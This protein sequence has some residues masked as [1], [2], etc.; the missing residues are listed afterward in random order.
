MAKPAPISVILSAMFLAA[1][2]AHAAERVA[3]SARVQVQGSS[4]A[5]AQLLPDQ[6]PFRM[7][8]AAAQAS[9]GS[10]PAYGSVRQI[11]RAEIVSAMRDAG[12]N[13]S[14]FTI[15]DEVTVMRSGR[16]LSRIEIFHAIE[17]FYKARWPGSQ[18]AFSPGDIEFQ[19]S[20]RV[21]EGDAAL[22]V[23]GVRYDQML[24]REIVRLLSESRP[25][26]VP[27]EV[28]VKMLP[29]P[30]TAAKFAPARHSATPSPVLVDPRYPAR[31]YLLSN[32]AEITMQVRPLQRG[33]RG[34]SIRV[35]LPQNGHT[36]L[37]RVV[38]QNTLEASF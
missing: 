28:A 24:N 37:A 9:L 19:N 15:P 12:L 4:V 32:A 33:R 34:D 27:F 25:D 5:L 38:S 2:S 20:I 18:V 8:A 22:S 3:I 16:T 30:G 17:S 11:Q 36:F 31:L 7:L 14:E 26:L 21:P 23:I 35:R 6:S 10:A 29:P 1:A 13:S